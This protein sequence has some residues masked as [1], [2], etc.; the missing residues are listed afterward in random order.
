MNYF[1]ELLESYNKLKKRTY[2]I[3][4][5][6]ES[7]TPEQLNAFPEIDS[8]IQA[9][10]AGN[11]QTGLGKNKNISIDKLF[12]PI[13]TIFNKQNATNRNKFLAEVN[14]LLVEDKS[15]KI[16]SELLDDNLLKPGQK[17]FNKETAQT[18]RVIM[19]ALDAAKKAK[20]SEKI[21]DFSKNADQAKEIETAIYG[22]LSNIRTR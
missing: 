2:K 20:L 7:Y 12:P 16:S 19:G 8:A 11:P 10:A 13:R 18:G 3:T 9:A 17:G 6:S 14:D 22:G 5:I 1:S 4:Y 21:A 15:M